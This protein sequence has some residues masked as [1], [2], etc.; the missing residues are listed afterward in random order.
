MLDVLTKELILL[1]VEAQ[2]WQQAVRECAKPLLQQKKI[3]PTYIDAIIANVL[4]SGPYIAIAPQV[5]I[6]HAQM[7]KGVL[8]SAIGITVL[9]NPVNFGNKNNDPIK[10]LFCLAAVDSSKHLKSLT[11][12]SVLLEDKNFYKVLD[13]AKTADE[14]IDFINNYERKEYV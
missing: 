10:Y 5:A 11:D 13:T 1:D 6:P 3:L 4:E 8:D 12:L 9:K 7:D 14:I 2:D